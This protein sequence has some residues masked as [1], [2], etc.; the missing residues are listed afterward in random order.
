MKLPKRAGL[1]VSPLCVA[2][3][4]GLYLQN[5]FIKPYV[6]HIRDVICMAEMFEKLF[7]ASLKN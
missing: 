6:I 5:L 4:A 7:H 2:V 1:P 3:C